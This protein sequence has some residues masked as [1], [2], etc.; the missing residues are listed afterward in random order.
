MRKDLGSQ[1][2]MRLAIR[3]ALLAQYASHPSWSALELVQR[4]EALALEVRPSAAAPAVPPSSV[5]ERITDAL[6]N[7]NGALPIR[8]LRAMCR[9]R[10]AIP[11]LPSM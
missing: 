8:Q 5:D 1:G 9:V 2:S 11:T 10:N 7:A 4:D 6:M 3:Q